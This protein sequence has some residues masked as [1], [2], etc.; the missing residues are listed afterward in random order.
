MTSPVSA[1]APRAARENSPPGRR[2]PWSARLFT[3]LSRR[4]LP[5][6]VCRVRVAPGIEVPAADGVPLRTDHYIPQLT[7]PRPA[8]LVRTP[9]GRGFPWASCS[10]ACS[11]SAG[12]PRD[13]PELPR[14]GRVGR[15]VPAVAARA[16]R[17]PGHRR[18]A[19]PAGLV[20]RRTGHHRAELPGLHPVGAG[21]RPAA[22]TTR[23]DRAGRRVRPVPVL[24]PGRRVRAGERAD[25]R[26]GHALWEDGSA[27][28][29]ALLRLQPPDA[30]GQPGPCR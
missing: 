17:R 16:G 15:D 10:V 26:R 3:R 20:H 4:G 11:P 30:A 7:G 23:H 22:R 19:A 27:L 29:R 5:P 13:H 12:Y 24:L 28:F 1:T 8:V 18:L 6:P 25:R 21:R 14:H 9:Y 2:L